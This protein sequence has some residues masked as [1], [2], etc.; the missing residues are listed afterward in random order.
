MTLPDW[1]LS[2]KFELLKRLETTR[3]FHDMVNMRT[4]G[5]QH[6]SRM[7]QSQS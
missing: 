6:S 3:H 1:G 4:S 2:L 7:E 5:K